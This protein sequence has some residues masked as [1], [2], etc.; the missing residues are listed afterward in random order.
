MF[1]PLE[2]PYGIK[3]PL[4]LGNQKSIG[5]IFNSPSPHGV[6]WFSESHFEQNMGALFGICSLGNLEI[7][8]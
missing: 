6:Q 8:K 7:M 5:T 3:V 4:F 1:I 2:T